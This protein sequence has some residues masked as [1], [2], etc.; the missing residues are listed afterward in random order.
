MQESC[1]RNLLIQSFCV[2]MI[3]LLCKRL[4][5]TLVAEMCRLYKDWNNTGLWFCLFIVATL[6]DIQVACTVERE[7]VSDV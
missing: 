3:I 5:G 2:P 1:F 7:M 6:V 4:M